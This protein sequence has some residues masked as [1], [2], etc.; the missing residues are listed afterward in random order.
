MSILRSLAKL[1]SRQLIRILAING[2]NLPDNEYIHC[3]WTP[4]E[5]QAIRQLAE[6]TELDEA[7]VLRQALRLYQWHHYKCKQGAR[8]AWVDAT[9]KL[10]PET[11]GCM[12]D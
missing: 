4:R 6:D 7:A 5:K 1:H 10:I 3:D 9:G 11:G 2:V 12:G 8:P